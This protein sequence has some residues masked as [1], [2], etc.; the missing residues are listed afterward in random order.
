MMQTAKKSLPTSIPAPRSMTAGIINF[1]LLPERANIST[2]KL[3]H[4]LKSTNQ[5]FLH[6]GW[7]RF[8]HGVNPSSAV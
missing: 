1:L 4:G 6:I 2:K 5:G 8:N 3:L 7:I